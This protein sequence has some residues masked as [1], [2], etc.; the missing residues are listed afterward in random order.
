MGVPGTQKNSPGC[1]IKTT[2]TRQ[3]AET[4]F[5]CVN[6]PRILLFSDAPGIGFAPNLAEFPDRTHQSRPESERSSVMSNSLRPH[7]LYSPWDSSGQDTGVGSLS[8][9]Q[10][11]FPTQGSN[12]GLPHCRRILYQLSHKGSPTVLVWVL[13]LQQGIFLTRNWT[14]V[15]C[16]AGRFFTN[17]AILV[18]HDLAGKF[19][20]CYCI[21]LTLFLYL[22][23]R[24][25]MDFY[26][27]NEVRW[28]LMPGIC[29]RYSTNVPSLSFFHQVLL[30]GSLSGEISSTELQTPPKL[31]ECYQGCHIHSKRIEFIHCI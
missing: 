8:L 18:K 14:R 24:I 16:T 6:C 4:L 11:I 20:V 22:D 25:A 29:R 9:L 1:W 5:Q 19:W 15:S 3:V 23:C 27:V 26:V 2:V 12:P 28:S 30:Y 17:R 7:G 13:V 10:G 31:F 21:S